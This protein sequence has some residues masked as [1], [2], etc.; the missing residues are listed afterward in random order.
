MK[1]RRIV[2]I[3][4]SVFLLTGGFFVAGYFRKNMLSKK[5]SYSSINELSQ[6]ND[7]QSP[8]IETQ[9]PENSQI[10]ENEELAVEPKKDESLKTETLSQV[11]PQENK[12]TEKISDTNE[13]KEPSSASGEIVNKLIN[14]GFQVS[15]SRNIDTIIVHSSYDAAGKDPYDIEGIIAEYK[16]YG[17]S[18]HYLIGRDGTIYQLVAEKNI[19]YHAGVSKTPDGRSNVNSFSIGIEMVNTKDGKFT[20]A[21]YGALNK[22]IAKEKQKYKIKYV[23][24]HDDIAPGRKTDPWN[25]DWNKVQR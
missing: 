25:I 18:A 11:K 5:K 13:I 21:Q 3:L 9:L 17:V 6:S 1:K 8:K 23:L 16:Q 7:Q 14:W 24:G 22:L 20:D 2:L 12:E 10:T 15:D 4:V 19:A